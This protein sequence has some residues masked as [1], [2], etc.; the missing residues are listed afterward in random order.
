MSAAAPCCICTQVFGGDTRFLSLAQ[1]AGQLV[2]EAGL[3]LKG[4]GLCHGTSGNAYAMLALHRTC[5][6]AAAAQEGSCRPGGAPAVAGA[7]GPATSAALQQEAA[8]WLQR[9]HQM[10]GHIGSAQGVSVNDV[11]DRYM[12]KAFASPKLFRPFAGHVQA[13]AR[14]CVRAHH[15]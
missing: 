12:R 4:H 1:R 11:P 10:A 2:W 14:A 5:A 15:E 13:P 6:S 7:V 9:A 3:L 8:K